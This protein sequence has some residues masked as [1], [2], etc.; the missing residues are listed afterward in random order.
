LRAPKA[1]ALG[2]KSL[3][4]GI[5]RRFAIRAAKFG[6]EAD[7]ISRREGREFHRTNEKRGSFEGAIRI[8]LR[9][10]L[11]LFNDLAFPRI[12]RNSLKFLRSLFSIPTAPTK[13]SCFQ[14]LIS[15]GTLQSEQTL[16]TKV[17]FR[18]SEAL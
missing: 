18:V 4:L 11:F 16:L 15:L 14:S 8:P 1:G 13:V 10:L 2:C 9:A 12:P 5:E 3:I 6:P 17:K 7:A